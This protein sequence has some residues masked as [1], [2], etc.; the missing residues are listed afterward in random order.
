MNQQPSSASARSAF[1]RI[2]LS[3]QYEISS[4]CGWQRQSNGH[5]VQAE[6]ERA[7]QQ[8]EQLPTLQTFAAGRTDTDVHAA[9][10]VVHFD[11]SERIPARKWAPALNGRLPAS[12]RV[13]ES[14]AR[15]ADWHACYSATY[16]RYR[17]T[18]YNLSLIHI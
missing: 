16:R 9:G 7:I 17:Y 1:R 5:S 2:A 13:R 18:I 15:P 11:C 14:V 3:L 4:F 12:I 8:L 10:Q 6:L